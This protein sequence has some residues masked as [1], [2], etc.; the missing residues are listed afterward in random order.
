MIKLHDRKIIS[1]D[2]ETTDLDSRTGRIMEVAG[3]EVEFF[4]DPKAK[5]VK[6]K[7]GEEF[8]TLVNPE[9]EPSP[10]ALAL[11]G[12]TKAELADA[13]LWTAVKPKVAKY[14]GDAAILGHNIWFDVN[15]IASQGLKLNAPILDSLE[16]AQTFLPLLPV[17]ALEYLVQEF[18]LPSEGSHR[19]LLD[20]K[21]AAELVAST[22]NSVL[23]LPAG[24][25]EE[26]DG[27]IA[28]VLSFAELFSKLP[29]ISS[30]AA[31]KSRALSSAV[32]S[33]QHF[34]F[35]WKPQTIF[36]TPLGFTQQS[37]WLGD[38]AK[39]K[40]KAVVGLS[41][42]SYLSEIP[43][44]QVLA[45]PVLAL[46]D[47]RLRTL[48]ERPELM[49]A[50][51]KILIK[52]AIASADPVFG[53]DLS[54][55]KWTQEEYPLLSAIKADPYVCPSH[56]CGYWQSLKFT[57]QKPL[58][59]SIF[60]LLRFALQWEAPVF[61]GKILLFDLARFE[62]SIADTVS[63]RY[64]AS[65]LRNLFAPVFPLPEHG[66]LPKSVPA[67]LEDFTND[68]DLFFG[69][70][71][72]VFR[73]RLERGSENVV[74]EE[75]E[76]QSEKF[77]Q[78]DGPAEK[79][80]KKFRT[81]DVFL[82]ERLS[83]VQGEEK[84]EIAG[85]SRSLAAAAEF[86][87][88]LF[89]SPRAEKNYWIRIDERGVE[90]N[91]APQDL[92]AA[93]QKFT[94]RF[95]S[96]T[97][98]DTELSQISL[99][100]FR[101]R[102]GLRDFSEERIF[103][104]HPSKRLKISVVEKSAGRAAWIQKTLASPG[105]AVVVVP[106]EGMLLELHGE[107]KQALENKRTVI[108]YRLSG[109]TGALR[110]RFQETTDAVLLITTHG[111]LRHF[112]TLPPARTLV[113]LRLPFEAPGARPGQSLTTGGNNFLLRV[114]PRAVN[115]LHVILSRFA[116]AKQDDQEAYLLDPRIFTDYDQAFL[117]YLQELPGVE[118]STA[119]F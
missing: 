26:I 71:H 93:W 10:Q 96:P 100:Y 90:L 70:L 87:E 106:N 41:H 28:P 113:M 44:S 17:H 83:M 18:A 3:V 22:L 82:R 46:C 48:K 110:R 13:P 101:N 43:P 114:V 51:R 68:I 75:P 88:E 104:D 37:A 11:T 4:F 76:R 103:S 81:V 111:L 39:Q 58:F 5:A 69:V 73:S 109:S 38:L 78:L 67:V 12:I 98:V 55:L 115:V 35:S 85:L 118:I 45:N 47:K 61:P 60:G 94:Q 86:F 53:Y 102:L 6:V 36:L 21:S 27:Y 72:L 91:G 32:P 59:C 62:D 42:E 119:K 77:Q 15:F 95:P 40:T 89:H 65:K 92:T 23:A 20:S 99:Q 19:A 52:I 64:G 80:L 66:G 34:D 33:R 54:R 30:F 56:D 50:Q 14:L 29:K 9:T 79:L 49:P 1:F 8:S 57:T 74:L 25:R 116:A 2:L 63:Q 117:K 97:F 105:R 112:Q 84:N 31:P 24:V 16:I 107:L 108:A 7:F